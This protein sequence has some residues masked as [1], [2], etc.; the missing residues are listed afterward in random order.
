MRLAA[1]LAFALLVPLP[2]RA[3]EAAWTRVTV[4]AMKT[5][6]YIGSVTL[7]PGAFERRGDQWSTTYAA[8]VF[9]W[10]PWSEHGDITITVTDADLARLAKGETV[11]FTGDAKNHKG[12]PRRVTGRAQ[13]AN[14]HAGKIKVRIHV[15]DVELIFN[16]TYELGR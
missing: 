3:A 9:P 16:G 14:D 11:E 5:S 1:L 15:D 2:V 10:F 7:T 12:K 8:K 13:P 4:P 6:I